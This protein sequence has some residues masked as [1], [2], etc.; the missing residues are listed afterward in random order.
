M[1][2]KSFTDRIISHQA[3]ITLVLS[4]FLVSYVLQSLSPWFQQI[5]AEDPVSNT[6]II[7]LIVDEAIYDAIDTE[8]QRY[9]TSYLQQKLSDTKAVVLPIN[10]DEY[11]AWDVVT[12]LDNLYFE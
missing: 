10:T 8:L 3:S 4:V 11:M 5:K 12:L 1:N 2:R 9:T 7:A 6:N